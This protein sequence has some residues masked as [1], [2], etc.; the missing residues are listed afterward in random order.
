MSL[1]TAPY[2]WLVCDRCGASSTEGGDYG[3]W[4]TEDSAYEEASEVDWAVR[5]E[6]VPGVV[7][8]LCHECKPA[9]GD[10]DEAWEE[11]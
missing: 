5:F 6:P 4:A 3:A 11:L 7:M 8:D 10:D 1:A 2:F 9:I